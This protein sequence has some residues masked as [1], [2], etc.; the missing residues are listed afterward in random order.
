MDDRSNSQLPLQSTLRENHGKI[1]SINFNFHYAKSSQQRSFFSLY[2][3]ITDPS[4]SYGTL[5]YRQSVV[6]FIDSSRG[7][8]VVLKL[9]QN[10]RETTCVGVS[11]YQWTHMCGVPQGSILGPML[12]NLQICLHLHQV[13]VFNSLTILPCIK[14]VKLKIY[15]IVLT[16]FKAMQSI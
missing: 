9:S 6:P 15:L 7:Q 3:H 5:G 16:F 10:G 2:C 4:I 8:Q 12:F 11:M 13:R 14:D 1:K